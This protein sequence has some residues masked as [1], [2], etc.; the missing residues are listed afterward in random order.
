MR[1][2]PDLRGGQSSRCLSGVPS[3]KVTFAF[4]ISSRL[5]ASSFSSRR[6]T[7]VGYGRRRWWRRSIE[8]NECIAP[9][10]TAVRVRKIRQV[11]ASILYRDTHGL[12]E[13]DRV[14][15]IVTFEHNKAATR[16]KKGIRSHARNDGKRASHQNR[17]A[18]ADVFSESGQ[19]CD[20]SPRSPGAAPPS[21]LRRAASDSSRAASRTGGSTPPASRRPPST[22]GRRPRWTRSRGTGGAARGGRRRA[23]RCRTPW[24]I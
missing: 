9:P 15:S 24:L 20:G 18:L 21:N 5:A 1:I 22:R 4:L 11:E 12:N 19:R 6:W 14:F 16:E 23:R 2:S 3:E 10:K 17:P 7:F 8:K 13:N